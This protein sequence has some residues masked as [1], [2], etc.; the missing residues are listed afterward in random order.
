MIIFAILLA[1]VIG[2]SSNPTTFQAEQSGQGVL[3]IQGTADGQSYQIEWLTAFGNEPRE[4][5]PDRRVKADSKTISANETHYY[6]TQI[7]EFGYPY[8]L[9]LHNSGEANILH[10]LGQK[11]GFQTL[12][13]DSE[14]EFRICRIQGPGVVCE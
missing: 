1:T 13:A 10:K 8:Y 6:E 5:R 7:D 9:R 4:W 11:D 12:G 14:I 3:T 2:C